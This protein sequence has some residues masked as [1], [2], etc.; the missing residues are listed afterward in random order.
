MVPVGADGLPDSSCIAGSRK[1]NYFVLA[2]DHIP[3]R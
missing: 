1:T 3:G 2:A